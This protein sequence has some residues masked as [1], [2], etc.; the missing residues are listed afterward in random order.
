MKKILKKIEKNLNNK[1]FYIINDDDVFYITRFKS[2]NLSLMFINGK[3]YGLTDPRYLEAAKNEIDGI[4]IIDMTNHNWFKEI[5]ESNPFNDL[6]INDN[7]VTVKRYEILKNFMRKHDVELKLFD[8]EYIRNAYLK[9]D[10]DTLRM[11]SEINDELITKAINYVKPGMTEK[12]LES[13][14]LKE[15]IDAPGEGPSF[16]PIVISGTNTSKPHGKATDR[17]INEGELITIDM[18]TIYKGFCSDMTR[19]FSL[20]KLKE[21][22]ASK[23]WDMVFEATEECTK[24]IKPGVNCADV[25]NK[26]VEVFKKYGYDKY[27]THGL[28]HGLGVEIHDKPAFNSMAKDKFLE[29]GMVMT[30]EP[31]L[32]I[33]GKYGCRLENA[34]L[35]TKD[36]YEVLNKAPY[37]KE[38]K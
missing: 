38:I 1:N 27:F 32:Y 19:T 26:A 13:Y 12:E 34:V 21:Q 11:A 4:E 6:Y 3:W 28:G 5:V 8:Y 31:G 22:E 23:I 9:E 7:D 18:G 15:I 2:S 37:I 29:E 36:G 10:L 24:M 25:H 35:V 17:V 30:V 14:I 20:G 33:P 16:E